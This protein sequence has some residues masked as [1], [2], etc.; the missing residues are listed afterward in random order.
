MAEV[1][2]DRSRRVAGLIRSE[3]MGLL[4]RGQVRDPGAAGATISGVTVTGD[5]RHA[6]VYLRLLDAEPATDARRRALLAA[7]G[8]ARGMLRREV[9]MR[10]GLRHAP[11]LEFH[12][13]EGLDHA[14]RV[15]SLLDEIRRESKPEQE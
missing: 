8:R 9:S 13:D 2:V 4:L 7:M 10:L 14:H 5:L 1:G 11:D 15:G 12:W 6:R 3:L